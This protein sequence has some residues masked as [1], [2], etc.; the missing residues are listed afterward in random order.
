MSSHLQRVFAFFGKNATASLDMNSALWL[1][2]IHA[3]A[4]QH[5]GGPNARLRA[6]SLS[7]VLLTPAYSLITT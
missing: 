2:T 5:P 3:G 4:N 1:N 7:L 6:D